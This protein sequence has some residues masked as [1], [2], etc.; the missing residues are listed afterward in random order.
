MYH[1]FLT[2]FFADFKNKKRL[3]LLSLEYI[4]KNISYTTIFI[5]ESILH[6]KKR[7]NRDG[8]TV[9]N[10]LTA[11]KTYFAFLS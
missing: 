9:Q 7:A 10:K 2:C 11:V 4:C 5:A 6:Q 1:S 8:D 3:D